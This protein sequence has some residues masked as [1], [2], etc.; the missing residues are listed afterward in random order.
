[1]EEWGVSLKIFTF[2]MDP[3]FD[4]VV[5]FPVHPGGQCLGTRVNEEKKDIWH[6]EDRKIILGDTHAMSR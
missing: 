5:Q 3:L 1:M 6:K 2:N 4:T